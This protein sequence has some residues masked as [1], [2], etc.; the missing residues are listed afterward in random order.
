M[1]YYCDYCDVYLTHDSQSGRK[2]HNKG[3]K[4]QEN[5]RQY[6]SQFLANNMASLPGM[7]GM[8][9][10]NPMLMSVPPPHHLTSPTD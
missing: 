2:Q 8:A 7:A 6:F 10:M 3:R 9:G 4:H 5:V 1:K